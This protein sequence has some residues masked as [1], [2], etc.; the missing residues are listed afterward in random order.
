MNEYNVTCGKDKFK[1]SGEFLTNAD[2][3]KALSEKYET[4]K[5]RIIHKGQHLKID[6][7]DLPE[8]GANLILFLPPDYKPVKTSAASETA[9][10][11]CDTIYLTTSTTTTTPVVVNIKFGSKTFLVH[12]N[13]HT[14]TIENIKQTISRHIQ[15]PAFRV[16][17]RGKIVTAEAAPV[18]ISGTYIF[19]ASETFHKGR[20]DEAWIRGEVAA[21]RDDLRG[22]DNRTID[23]NMRALVVSAADRRCEELTG[24]VEELKVAEKVKVEVKTELVKMKV[25]CG[26]LKFVR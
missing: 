17:H 11:S 20:D 1:V 8:N 5:I 10:A 24:I 4:T 6:M 21:L 26:R 2:L 3:F 7:F 16:V 18:E 13:P 15:I 14:D 9:A 23:E 19:F 22:V 25:I 12:F